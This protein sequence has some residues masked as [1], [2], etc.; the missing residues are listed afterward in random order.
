M[1]PRLFE[2]I[3]HARESGMRAVLSTNGTLITPDVAAQLKEFGLSYVG[4]SL[5]GLEETNDKFRG[6]S[7][8]YRMALEG[9][10]NC[11]EAGIK[12]GLRFTMNRRN[13][14]DIGG[15]FDLLISEDIPACLFLP[16]R[17]CRQRKQARQRGSFARGKPRTRWT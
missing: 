6:V 2:L 17:L 13:A 10:R 15:I 4:V 5:D 9:I 16:P 8:A 3:A 1:R 12:V 14:Q 11:R 7:G